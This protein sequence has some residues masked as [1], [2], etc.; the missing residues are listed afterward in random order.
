[1]K[2]KIKFKTILTA[3]AV[4]TSLGLNSKSYA[5]DEE[6]V[7]AIE[8]EITDEDLSLENK[9]E[10]IKEETE[11][12]DKII[13]NTENLEESEYK[14]N[15]NIKNKNSNVE[16]LTFEKL[17]NPKNVEY[18]EVLKLNEKLETTKDYEEKI[19]LIENTKKNI[20]DTELLALLD[21]IKE[22]LNKKENSA[23]NL[24]LLEDEPEKEQQQT[25]ADQVVALVMRP[26]SYNLYE[27]T[28][29]EVE[30]GRTLYATIDIWTS[31]GCDDGE[32]R[33][34]SY[35]NNDKI[36][37]D[38][39]LMNDWTLDFNAETMEE[40]LERVPE[41]SELSIAI[42]NKTGVTLFNIYKFTPPEDFPLGEV[43]IPFRVTFS[44][45]SIKN[46]TYK[47]NVVEKV[48]DA[49]RY[50]LKYPKK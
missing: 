36:D 49:D 42:N 22:A 28:K 13:E 39:G 40:Y 25:I 14:E 12:E 8:K 48:N 47:V 2:N 16:Y 26:M 21:K 45:M 29:N 32:I 11:K 5:S 20:K 44:D 17:E 37:K 33:L 19:Q 10:E 38:Y 35:P 18:E 31:Y 27:N 7:E 24:I 6:V 3:V 43:E 41:G 34:L 15:E 4:A 9:N 46:F 50:V 30:R 23:N 1:M